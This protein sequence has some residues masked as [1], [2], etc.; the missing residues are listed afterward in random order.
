VKFT[1]NERA[2][3]FKLALD[4]GCSQTTLRPG[5]MLALGF[6][7]S[8]ALRKVS[9]T[10][11]TR[12]ESAY[13]YELTEMATLGWKVKTVRLIAKDLPLS[14]PFDGLLGLDFFRMVKKKLTVD[15]EKRE[16]KLE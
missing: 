11:G 14:L 6:K 1:A 12:T 8:D 9:V 13:E 7:T 15:F 5:V 16:L 3:F 10:T 4:T 2:A